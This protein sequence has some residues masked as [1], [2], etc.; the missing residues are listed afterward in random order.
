MRSAPTKSLSCRANVRHTSR[1][2]RLCAYGT[3]H[4]GRGTCIWVVLTLALLLA[5]A[6]H[7]GGPLYVAGSGFNSGTA[8]TPLTWAGGQISYYTDQGDLSSLLHQSDANSFVADAF[9]LWT[10]VSTAAVTATRAGP[11]DEDVSGAN[12]TRSGSVLGMPADIQPTSAK[13]FAIVYDADGRVIDALLGSGASAAQN[14]G[15]NAVVGGPDRFTAD[16]HIAHALLILNGN[17]ARA[18]TDLALLHYT[19]A[20]MIGRSLG[21]DWSQLNDKVVNPR[22]RCAR[23]CRPRW[24]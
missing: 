21:L 10:S 2:H 7:A 5:P 9:S 23:A 4:P 12:V 3:A 20:R 1:S 6:A 24:W 19:L 18:P 14:C 11:L 15:A 8:G 17:C 22:E 16:A 13:P